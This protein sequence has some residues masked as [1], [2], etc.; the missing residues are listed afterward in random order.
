MD[1]VSQTS[2]PAATGAALAPIPGRRVDPPAKEKPDVIRTLEGKG[3]VWRVLWAVK[4]RVSGA[5][6]TLLAGGTSYYAFLA[7]F[8]V[9]AF[10]YGIAALVSAERVSRWMT[11][12]LEEALPGLV[13]EGGLDP[14]TLERVG[15]SA[16]LIGLVVLLYSGSA[17]MVAASDSL[18]RI[19]GAEADGRNPAR[20]RLHLFLWLGVLGPLIL[21]SYTLSTALGAFSEELLDDIGLDGA[22]AR[23]SVV[24]VATLVTFVLDVGITFLLLTRLGGIRP[25]L[26]AALIGAALGAV[27][28][29]L[30]KALMATIVAWSV[31]K[32]QYGS[33]A[34]PISILVVLWFQSL[35]LYVAAATTAAT[36]TVA[37]HADAD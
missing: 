37:R 28:I 16:S 33:F 6:A 8:S 5:Q 29:S 17:V 23:A 10:A 25:P 34:V 32:P 15:R 21:V 14:A 35:A 12:A 4:E 36:A 19:Y 1:P 11:N 22:L 2:T 26:R 13:G 18:H 3:V 9:L 20:R 7:M 24:V 30:L 31:D 27:A